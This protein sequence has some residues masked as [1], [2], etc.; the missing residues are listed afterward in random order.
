M[1]HRRA[2]DG[3]AEVVIEVGVGAQVPA[4][5]PFARDAMYVA[6]DVDAALLD[7]RRARGV[8]A[9]ATH[10]PFRSGSVDHIVACNVFGDVGL[11]HRFEEVVGMDPGQYA[12]HVADLV[13]RGAHGELLQ[14]RTKVRAMTAAVDATKRAIL[15]DAAR[16]LRHDGEIIVVETF[17]PNFAQEWIQYTCGGRVKDEAEF[18]VDGAAFR[19]RVVRSHNRRR[20]YCDSSELAHQSLELWVLTAL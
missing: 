17:T 13:K 3:G 12:D 18:D 20:R 10:L 14:L 9:T 5:R 1:S 19:C 2:R 7:A 11:G 15:V 16:V 8:A 4:S 6:V